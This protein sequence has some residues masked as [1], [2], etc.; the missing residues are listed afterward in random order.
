MRYMREHYFKFVPNLHF[1]TKLRDVQSFGDA[2]WYSYDYEM[3]L[4]DKRMLGRG[5]AMCRKNQGRWT[6][7]N[8]HNS[9]RTPDEQASVPK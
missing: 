6:V 3:D 1:I 2:L 4:G 9:L 8:M 7:L 5:M